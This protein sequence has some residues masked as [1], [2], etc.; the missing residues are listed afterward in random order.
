MRCLDNAQEGVPVTRPLRMATHGPR[1]LELPRAALLPDDQTGAEDPQ[2]AA[3]PHPGVA[4][5]P[6]V[7][8]TQ[9]RHHADPSILQ[10]VV[11]TAANK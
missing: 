8:P 9:G 1:G 7:S 3:R 10:R 6:F 11:K 4:W 2:L 5:T